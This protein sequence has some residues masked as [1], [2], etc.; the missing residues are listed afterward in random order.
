MTMWIKTCHKAIAKV[1]MV[2]PKSNAGAGAIFKLFQTRPALLEKRIKRPAAAA[3][4][5]A[6]PHDD[7]DGNVRAGGSDSAAALVVMDGSVRKR[8]RLYS[9]SHTYTTHSC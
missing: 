2:V 6:S 3:Q 9:I 7:D 8:P 4:E 5:E 1:A